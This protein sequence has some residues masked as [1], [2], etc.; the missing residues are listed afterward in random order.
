MVLVSKERQRNFDLC[1]LME[2][3]G[4]KDRKESNFLEKGRHGVRIFIFFCF[5]FLSVLV[6]D[7]LN[8][9]D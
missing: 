5:Y 7:L 2:H 4:T 1:A 3:N 9:I 8:G 6:F